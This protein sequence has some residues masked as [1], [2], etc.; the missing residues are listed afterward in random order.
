MIQESIDAVT[1][2][3]WEKLTQ[4]ISNQFR[5]F[6]AQ[7]DELENQISEKMKYHKV[8]YTLNSNNEEDVNAA[9][10]I[11]DIAK[12]HIN[13]SCKSVFVVHD[14]IIN[15]KQTLLQQKV[16]K[17]ELELLH[18]LEE[19]FEKISSYKPVLFDD[20]FVEEPEN[21]PSIPLLKPND[22]QK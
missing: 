14:A 7:I 1:G 20:S 18:M 2:I 15:K 12:D 4:K 22:H 21:E 6:R 13:V 8:S 3:A 19:G 17:I 10:K 16:E 9:I 5:G 11:L